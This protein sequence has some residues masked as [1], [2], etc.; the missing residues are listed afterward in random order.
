[1][2]TEELKQGGVSKSRS[3]TWVRTVRKDSG[4]SK[5]KCLSIRLV[6]SLT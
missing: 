1:M 4:S 2:V 6:S 3:Q 5:P